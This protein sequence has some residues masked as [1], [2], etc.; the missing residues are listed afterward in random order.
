LSQKEHTHPI[1]S[2]KQEIFFLQFPYSSAG[3]GRRPAAGG[4]GGTP[5]N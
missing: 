1:K 3:G 5:Q 2:K 4:G